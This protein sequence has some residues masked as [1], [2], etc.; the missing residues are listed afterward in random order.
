MN[1]EGWK[2]KSPVLSS[3]PALLDPNLLFCSHGRNH[4]CGILRFS[5]SRLCREGG[6]CFVAEPVRML[7]SRRLE[8][9]WTPSHFVAAKIQKTKR[10]SSGQ[11]PVINKNQDFK[12]FT[13]EIWI[14]EELWGELWSPGK[15]LQVGVDI[16]TSPC[17][18]NDAEIFLCSYYK[19][20]FDCVQGGKYPMDV[21]LFILLECKQDASNSRKGIFIFKPNLWDLRRLL[22]VLGNTRGVF[23]SK[24]SHFEVLL[25]PFS[26]PW[27]LPRCINIII[28]DSWDHLGWTRSLRWSPTITKPCQVQH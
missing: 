19:R 4:T 27:W 8:F 1:C 9:D 7:F 10:L 2:R 18:W 3:P 5:L 16:F 26:S 23:Y 20:T 17:W 24:L 15:I 11:I 25:M 14:N 21:L 12:V 13:Q 28:R 6:I 22:N